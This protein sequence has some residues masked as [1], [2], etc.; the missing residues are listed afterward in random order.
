MTELLNQLYTL[1]LLEEN[2]TIALVLTAFFSAILF[3]ASLVPPRQNFKT[4]FI[5]LI[6]FLASTSILFTINNRANDIRKLAIENKDY[7]LTKKG[8]I[9]EL[10]SYTPYIKSKKLTII[11]QDDKRIQVE[12][13]DDY[14]E[15]DKSQEKINDANWPSN[16]S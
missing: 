16:K 13:N 14:F 1:P 5:I 10:T 6:T 4:S 15:I 9:L 2:L 3:I 8:A 12:Y 7:M 11:Y